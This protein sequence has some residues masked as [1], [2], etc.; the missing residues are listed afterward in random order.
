M[1]EELYQI[2]NKARL[3]SKGYSQQEGTDYSETYA[4]VAPLEVIHILL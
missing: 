2:E 3:V 4:S 1:Q